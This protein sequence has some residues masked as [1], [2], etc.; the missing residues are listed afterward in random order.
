MHVSSLCLS[1]HPPGSDTSSL[2]SY[3][4][5]SASLPPSGSL[6]TSVTGTLATDGGKN[7]GSSRAYWKSFINGIQRVV[8]FTPYIE[9]IDRIK[10]VGSYS[11][12][13]LELSLSLR[14]VGISLVDNRN[15]RELAYIAVT[16]YEKVHACILLFFPFLPF[17][18]LFTPILSFLLMSCT[19]LS[20]IFSS[21]PLFLYRYFQTNPS[22]PLPLVRP[23][24][25][26]WSDLA[27]RKGS[28]EVE[29]SQQ[30]DYRLFRRG[31]SEKGNGC[32]IQEP[33]SEYYYTNIVFTYVP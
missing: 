30:H 4:S 5:T 9:A 16:Q 33:S 17:F 28:Q 15:K 12:P 11:Q 27:S 25:Q 18:F 32:Q 19:S 10:A 8:L 22:Q 6:T 21:F 7:S 13:Q 31:P 2:S 24:R 20:L 26:I 14:A 3:S 29:N 23:R 1:V